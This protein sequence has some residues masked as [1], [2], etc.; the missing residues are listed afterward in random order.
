MASN[1]LDDLFVS[2]IAARLRATD[3]AG[4]QT[5]LVDAVVA[6]IQTAVTSG[7]FTATV[8]EGS[9][10]SADIQWVVEQLITAGYGVTLSST[11]LVITW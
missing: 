4:T 5:T 9:A 6:G 1:T 7:L 8:A 10:T 11:N 2:A 3:H